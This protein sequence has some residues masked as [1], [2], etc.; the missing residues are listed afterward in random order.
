MVKEVGPGGPESGS[1]LPPVQASGESVVIPDAELLVT[2]DYSRIGDDLFLKGTDGS[3]LLVEGYYAVEPAPALMSP[4]GLTLWPDQIAKL[5]GPMAPGQIAQAGPVEGPQPI[6]QVE[7]VTG[8]VLAVRAGG[9]VGLNVGDAV[10]QDDVVQTG[11]GSELVIGFADGTMFTLSENARMTLDGMV[12]DPNGDANSLVTSVIHGGFSFITGQIAPT[13]EMLVDTPIATIGIRGTFVN[14]FGRS[15]GDDLSCSASTDQGLAANTVTYERRDT[16]EPVASL[17]DPNSIYTIDPQLAVRVRALNPSEELV[18][19]DLLEKLGTLQETFLF[20]FDPEQPI[21]QPVPARR[22]EAEPTIQSSGSPFQSLEQALAEVDGTEIVEGVEG[23][24]PLDNKTPPSRTPPPSDPTDPTTSADLIEEPNEPPVDVDVKVTADFVEDPPFS[25]PNG[26]TNGGGSNGNGTEVPSDENAPELSVATTD[27]GAALVDAIL[28]SGVTLVPDSIVYTGAPLASGLFVGGLSAGIGIESGIILTSG[29]AALAVGPNLLDDSDAANGLPGDSDLDGLIP[30]V[31]LDATVLEFDFTTEGGDV[32]FNFV[33]ASEEYNEFALSDVNDVFGFFLDGVNI[34]VIPGTTTPISINNVNGGNPF[35]SGNAVNPEFFNNNDRDDGGPF[36]NIEYDGFTNVFTA[37]ATGLAPGVHSIKLAIADAGDDAY[38]SAVFIQAG[39]FSDQP[40][41]GLGPGFLYEFQVG[42]DAIT[43]DDNIRGTDAEDGFTTQFTITT[44]PAVGLLLID[45]NDDGVIEEIFGGSF[46]ALPTGGVDV[47]TGDSVFYFLP[48]SDFADRPDSVMFNYFTTDS[49]GLTSLNDGPAVV[50]VNLPNDTPTVIS[51]E[52]Q[53]VEEDDI[54]GP[55]D[56]GGGGIGIAADQEP[57][58]DVVGAALGEVFNLFDLPFDPPPFDL[59]PS[60]A[61]AIVEGGISVD[62]GFDELGSVAFTQATVDALSA[63][64]LTSSTA[65]DEAGNDKPLSYAISP[66]GEALVGFVDVDGGGEFDVEGDQVVFTVL[67]EPPSSSGEFTYSFALLGSIN[68]PAGD[69]FVFVADNGS[70]SILKIGLNGS[71]IAFAV[72][73]AEIE[74]AIDGPVDLEESGVQVDAA[75][76]IFFAT[77]SV[78]GGQPEFVLVKPADGGPVQVVASTADVNS[79]TGSTEF[80]PEG[81]ALAAD[82]TLYAFDESGDQRVIKITDPLG[83]PSISELADGGD[84]EAALRAKLVA[85]DPT[86]DA[87]DGDPDFDIDQGIAISADGQTLYIPVAEIGFGPIENADAIIALDAQT[88][89]VSVLTSITSSPFNNLDEFIAVAPNGDI[90]VADD[91]NNAGPDS[92]DQLHRIDPTSGAVTP[93][94]S[95]QD[96]QDAN[97]GQQVDPDGGFAFDAAGNFYLADQATGNVLTWPVNDLAAGTIQVGAGSILATKDAIDDLTGIFDVDLDAGLD[98]GIMLGGAGENSIALPFPFQAT[99]TNGD[100]VQASFNVTV[101]DD[102]PTIAPVIA[103]IGRGELITQPTELKIWESDIDGAEGAMD[104]TTATVVFGADGA[105][106]QGDPVKLTLTGARALPFSE[107]DGDN[108]PVNDDEITFDINPDGTTTLTSMGIPVQVRMEGPT[109]IVGFIEVALDDGQA[110]GFTYDEYYNGGGIEEEIVFEAFLQAGDDVGFGIDQVKFIFEQLKAIDHPDGMDMDGAEGAGPFGET[111]NLDQIEL[112]FDVT[113]QDDDLDTD[114]LTLTVRI[115]DDGPVILD[116]AEVMGTVEEEQLSGGNE[117]TAPAEDEDMVVDGGEIFQDVTTD[118]ASG[119]VAALVDFGADEPGTFSLSNDVTDLLAQ[120]LASRGEPL[121]YDVQGNTLTA[122]AGERPVFTL[123]LDSDGDYKFT[124]LDQLDH[125]PDAGENLL[126]IDFSSLVRAADFDGDKATLNTGT[127]TIKVIDDIPIANGAM[128][129]GTVEEEQLSGGNED[130]APAEDE[131]MVVD[132]GEVFQDVTTDMASGSVAALVDFGADGPADDPFSLS[133]ITTDLPTLLSQGETVAYD[134]Q[135]NTLTGTAGERPVFT[136]ELQTNG[137]YK[138]TLLD[139]LD[140]APGG[141]ENLLAIDFSS[142]VRATDFDGDS[143]SLGQGRFIIKVIDDTPMANGAMEMG[144]V[145]E[146]QLSGGIEDTAPAEDL[147]ID[148]GTFFVDTTTNMASGSVAGLVSFG[149]DGPAAGGGFSLLADTSELAALSSQGEPVLYDVTGNTLTATAGERP[150]F[151]LELQ[152]NGDYTFTLLDRLNHA[153]G[154][155]E[156]LLAIDVSSLVQATDFDGDT[157]TL[158]QGAFTIKVIDDVPVIDGAEGEPLVVQ[159]R[160]IED[161]ASTTLDVRFGAD[162]PNQDMAALTLRFVP[163][164]I[165]VAESPSETQMDLPALTTPDGDTVNVANI[166]DLTVVGFVDGAEGTPG[167][168]DEQTD[169]AVFRATFNLTTE[170]FDFTLIE[171]LAHPDIGEALGSDRIRLNFD[172]TAKD[173]D[174]DTATQRVVVDIED[175]APQAAQPDVVTVDEDDLT[176]PLDGTSTFDGNDTPPA[177]PL[178]KTGGLG[179]DFGEDGPRD[180]TDVS[181]VSTVLSQGAVVTLMRVG[182]SDTYIGQAAGRDVFSLSF[183]VDAQAYTFTLL[184]NLDHAGSGENLLA[185]RF[186]F[187]AVDGDLDTFPTE[188]SVLVRD[189]VPVV[190]DTDPVTV[191]EDDLTPPLA[192]TS[193]FDGNDV[194]PAESLSAMGGIGIDFGADGA[195]DIIGAGLT[196]PLLSQGVDVLLT[197]NGPNS[198]VGEAGSRTVFKIDFNVEAGTYTFT[199]LD[200]LD[201]PAGNGENTLPVGFRILARD[202]DGDVTAGTVTVNVIDDAPVANDNMVMGTVEEEQ[203][204][205]GNE[206]TAPEQ[207]GDTQADFNVTTDTVSDSVA[208]LVSFGADGPAAGGGFSLLSDVTALAAQGLT[209]KGGTVRY[210]VNGDTLTGFVDQGVPGGVFADGVDRKVFSLELDSDGG[211]T[212]TLIDQLDHPPGAGENILTIDF[213]SVLRA[214]DFDGDP[215]S[216]DQGAFTIKVIDDVPLADP[217]GTASVKVFEDALGQGA[218]EAPADGSTGNLDNNGDG[219]PDVDPNADEATFTAADLEALIRPGADDP[220]TLALNAS[221]FGTVRAIDGA[222][223][224]S[225]G[226]PVTYSMLSPTVIQGVA[227]GRVV[228]TLTDNG[229]GTFTFDLDD[230]LDHLPLELGG[231]DL[232]TLALDLTPAFTA[233]DFDRDAVALHAGSIRVVVENDVPAPEV[234]V[235]ASIAVFEDAL[236]QGAPEGPADG[237]IGNLDNDGNGTPDVDPEADAATFSA[238]EL[239]AVVSSGADDPVSVALDPSVTGFVLTAGGTLVTSQGDPVTYSV[240]SPTQVQGVAGGRVV[241]TL[242]DN[243]NGTFTFDLDDQIDHL[244]LDSGGGDLETLAL[245]LTPAFAAKDFDGDAVALQAGSIRV[246][247]E[248]DVPQI[249]GGQGEVTHDET[250]G[251]DLDADDIDPNQTRLPEGL[252]LAIATL[253]LMPIGSAKSAVDLVTF[254]VGADDPGR[255]SL[256]DA[257]GG[258]LYREDSG[259]MRSSDGQ[260][261]FLFTDAADPRLVLGKA[262]MGPAAAEAGDVVFAL[263]MDESDN[264][265]W[266]T[267]FEGVEHLIDS[268]PVDTVSMADKVF[269][270]VTDADGDS[271]TT[272]LAPVVSF[273][274]DVPDALDDVDMVAPGGMTDGNVITGDDANDPDGTPD[275]TEADDIGTDEPGLIRSIEHDGITYALNADCSEIIQTGQA[276]SENS[277]FVSFDAE[278]GILVIDTAEGGRLSIDLKGTDV[279]A[280]TY[281]APDSRGGR[282]APE[283]ITFDDGGFSAGD[284][285]SQV[286]VDGDSGP[287]QVLG[288]NPSFEPGVNAAMIFDSSNPTGGDT[289]LGTPNQDFGGP[290]VG[291]GGGEG[292]PFE[293][294][295]ALGN[296]LI[297]SEDLD[298]NDPD[299]AAVEG[300][301]IRFDFSAIGPVAMNSVTVIDDQN[302]GSEVRFFDGSGELI[303]TIPLPDPGAN[304]VVDVPFDNVAGVITMEIVFNGSGA[305]DNIVFSPTVKEDVI[306]EFV[307]TLEDADGDTDTAGLMVLVND[308]EQ[309]QST[310]VTLNAFANDSPTTVH[311]SGP[312]PDTLVATSG[313]DIFV[314]EPGDGGDT[315]AMADLIEGFEDGTDLIGL[316]GGLDPSQIVVGNDGVGNATI[317]IDTGTAREILA[318]LENVAQEDIDNSD[319]LAIT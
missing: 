40:T 45:R 217:E 180:I 234:E 175:D 302:A 64:G 59:P 178:T 33:F 203:L 103:D 186:A 318:V 158:D 184:D 43:P 92:G 25:F 149:A 306:E 282:G 138:F 96:L 73:Q 83:T 120:N 37:T 262:G 10:F 130:T 141:G 99:D 213:S 266:V 188:L 19:I 46:G 297:V 110:N 300:T 207:D 248:N 129:M 62:F 54:V 39:S 229:D 88:G 74:N 206:D 161:S 231:G 222:P 80:E 253:G 122:T 233:E 292:S 106:M 113:V 49:D 36:F 31:T 171:A 60:D 239:Q 76:N 252:A 176:P 240:L 185:L 44:L 307:Y 61:P 48:Q 271:A 211:Y 65:K 52:D 316:G 202:G 244:P 9:P 265:L 224:M 195:R 78:E 105:Q 155:G 275:L 139:Q 102:I 204:V 71:Q 230:Q 16:G 232:E 140:H 170:Q 93:F 4:S 310:S 163:P 50:M 260:S 192:G 56:I 150:V 191:D 162:G 264:S 179:V 243:G 57:G 190:T 157:T 208:E 267:Q 212:F 189:D 69:E 151:T 295:T 51:A 194:P 5:V 81:L 223:V 255:L 286:F 123:T 91:G 11:L 23:L 67:L 245:D 256:T 299:D 131:D 70:N 2:A 309:L 128:E 251:R 304:G 17:T 26:D 269:V 115:D 154:E 279:G 273:Q 32:F 84:I 58:S 100:T 182:A 85:E 196:A 29:N 238:A 77:D 261:I 133:S 199:L 159:E 263:F 246:V 301:A 8:D 258:L 27:S 221:V 285:V 303:T 38:D 117:D 183:D 272:D 7:Q 126:A 148:G 249:E 257:N 311:D 142:V 53:S 283:T 108:T 145:E 6:G 215:V 55:F 173:G 205:G 13:G 153:P 201:H 197:G 270:T 216:F 293:N 90:I 144:T 152:P 87:I 72:T 288:I 35:G 97:G 15:I 315:L 134:V 68:H 121:A 228:F 319:F 125:A 22:A 296:V 298:S 160:L 124:L 287:I 225:Q 24:D 116:G 193:T 242:T 281:E 66:D 112:T 174:G 94:L 227:A 135:G 280:Y 289:D 181:L 226:D 291:D 312:G 172:L 3:T 284:I 18:L 317:S 237:S 198:F 219:I 167:V 98:V 276:Q 250:P 95:N 278:T 109:K 247:V 89:A 308:G 42:A 241:F 259:L 313:P 107:E 268:D 111:V 136:L 12:Y 21:F 147:D 314:Y 235:T 294:G 14:C 277:G 200:N 104:M 236:G 254:D 305:V 214:T 114:T 146:E 220:V 169:T 143:I 209:S 86:L 20:F 63:L 34:A 165:D 101:V 210:D 75:G 132:G 218:P 41:T 137:D 1:A 127:F 274:D 118:M 164:A 30:E 166:D 177:E 79:A 168:F 119:S 47:Q 290:G 28:G 156:N 82:G 187:T